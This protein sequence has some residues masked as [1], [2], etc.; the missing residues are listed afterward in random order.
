MVGCV[1][2]FPRENQK[3]PWKP[4]FALFAIFFTGG[5]S[6][7]RPLFGTFSRAVQGF[8]GHF[9]IFFTGW[10]IFFTYKSLKIFTDGFLIFTGRL[11]PIFLCLRYFVPGLFWGVKNIDFSL[12]ICSIVKILNAQVS[13]QLFNF[14][15]PRLHF[16]ESCL[17]IMLT[18][19]H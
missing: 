19:N 1:F 9:Q 17:L 15:P 14:A 5:N 7:S 8:H 13:N 12:L 2:F 11:S 10:S 6:F 3:C 18:P 4:F 16:P